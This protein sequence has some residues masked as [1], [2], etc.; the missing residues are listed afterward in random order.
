MAEIAIIPVETSY[1]KD[2]EATA[3]QEGKISDLDF[4]VLNFL[5]K[6]NLHDFTAEEIQNYIAA[7]VPICLR[8][9]KDSHLVYNRLNTDVEKVW[10][11]VK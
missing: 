7:E 11:S 1:V 3:I 2:R 8:R 4:I 5:R 6:N 10:Y 9:L